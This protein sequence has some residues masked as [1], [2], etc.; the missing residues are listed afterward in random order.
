MGN[1]PA[2][3]RHSDKQHWSVYVLVIIG[4]AGLIIALLAW[5]KPVSPVSEQPNSGPYTNVVGPGLPSINSGKKAE[6]TQ[7]QLEESNRL[8]KLQD[9]ELPKQIKPQQEERQLQAPEKAANELFSKGKE[10]DQLSSTPIPKSSESDSKQQ[11]NPANVKIDRNAK[12][13]GGLRVK[14]DTLTETP[15]KELIATFILEN[16]T[17]NTLGSAL[18]VAHQR[19]VMATKITDK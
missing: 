1:G 6:E 12:E 7:A 13:I 2:P 19:G 10:L 5:L 16:I 18:A 4:S 9:A 11:V 15:T 14:V 17:T 3:A 8:A